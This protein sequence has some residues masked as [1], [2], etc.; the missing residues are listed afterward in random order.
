MRISRLRFVLSG[1][2]STLAVWAACHAV[3]DPGNTTGTPGST[4]WELLLNDADVREALKL[5]EEDSRK[6]QQAFRTIRSDVLSKYR[7]YKAP[8]AMEAAAKASEAMEKIYAEADKSM[9][10]ILTAE[11]VK[12]LKQIDRQQRGLRDED[13]R[14]E[15]KLSAEQNQQIQKIRDSMDKDYRQVAKKFPL[16]RKSRIAGWQELHKKTVASETDVLTAEQ[17]K[18]WDELTGEPFY[19]LK[20]D[21]SNGIDPKIAV[22]AP[23]PVRPVY[24]GIPRF[25]F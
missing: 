22:A 21:E 12:R 3:S 17:R 7:N 9:A 8:N 6:L 5:S 13:T 11:Q 14:K 15:L 19:L 20:F 24:P 4:S 10:K 18:L 25:N 16:D 2:L 23:P 1:T